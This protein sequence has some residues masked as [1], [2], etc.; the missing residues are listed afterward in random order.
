MKI[1]QIL[2]KP[3]LPDK[4]QNCPEFCLPNCYIGMEYEWEKTAAFKAVG[5]QGAD[6]KFQ[7]Y[8]GVH[9]DGSLR[10]SGMEFVFNGP[11]A[12]TNLLTA[13]KLMDEIARKYS[14][15]SS[16][17]TSLHVHL[18]MTECNFP[19][20]V[21]LLGL[22]YSIFEPLIY[23]FVGQ[24]RDACNYCIPWYSHPQHYQV[25]IGA[26][27]RKYENPKDYAQHLK[28][29][30]QY[31]YSGLNFFSLGDF[32]TLEWRQ[33]PVDMQKD[34][35]IQWINIIMRHKKYVLD[36]P[37]A[38]PDWLLTYASRQE[39]LELLTEVFQEQGKLLSRFTRNLRA[40]INLGL[41]TATHYLALLKG[42]K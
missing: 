37:K 25:F 11:F 14:F 2:G 24:N 38:Q 4:E 29:S 27:E 32:G 22:L 41:E 42:A 23:K 15:V 7:D 39:P 8:F 35:I 31:K 20:D 36:H 34:K 12:G 6:S 33:A 3:A 40:D 17:R 5:M 26:M 13:I 21:Y 9:N 1:K 19:E 30:K 16:Y 10:N 18:D 28:N